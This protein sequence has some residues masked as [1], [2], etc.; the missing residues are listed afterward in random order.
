[1][2]SVPDLISS[3]SLAH[4]S[5]ISRETYSRAESD[6][7]I[8]VATRKLVTD[9]MDLLDAIIALEAGKINADDTD[10][11][12]RIEQLL[13][14]YQREDQHAQRQMPS[15]DAAASLRLFHLHKVVSALVEDFCTWAI[16]KHPRSGQPHQVGDLS[17]AEN[18]RIQRAFFRW[19]I[20]TQLFGQL[21]GTTRYCRYPILD[22]EQEQARLFV[23]HLP[24]HEVEELRCIEEYSMQRYK[25]ILRE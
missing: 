24:W 17:L 23:D 6:I 11:S 8:T 10:R 16:S 25:S 7:L 21:E 4:C 15:L 13:E 14:H 1:M 19:E 3:H 22:S 12:A 20:Y 5:P 18:R 9:E 2:K